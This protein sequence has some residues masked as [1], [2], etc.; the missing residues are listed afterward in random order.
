[1]EE[2]VR[3]ARMSDGGGLVELISSQCWDVSRHTAFRLCNVN[4]LVTSL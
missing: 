4:R 3:V 2:A 1:M